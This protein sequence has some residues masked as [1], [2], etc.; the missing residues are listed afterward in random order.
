MNIKHIFALATLLTYTSAQPFEIRIE[1]KQDKENLSSDHYVAH[2][3]SDHAAHIS[4]GVLVGI[5]SRH[6]TPRDILNFMTRCITSP[7]RSNYW[8]F[9][10]MRYLI[11]EIPSALAV[12]TA[13]LVFYKTPQWTDK[14]LLEKKTERSTKKNIAVFLSRLLIP[15]PFGTLTGEYFTR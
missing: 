1:T 13:L 3:L 15:Y 9:D 5:A 6:M 4:M 7:S 10:D 11:R 2:L 14:H 8:Y 12:A